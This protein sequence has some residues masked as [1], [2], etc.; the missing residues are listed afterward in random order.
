[1][2]AEARPQ[3]HWSAH[4]C[5]QAARLGMASSQSWAEPAPAA[6]GG[7]SLSWVV[8]TSPPEDSEI[9]LMC[10]THLDDRSTAVTCRE[11]R[12]AEDRPRQHMEV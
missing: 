7:R 8:R 6:R 12:P 1:M 9:D 5:V 2:H 10:E 3:H 4:P 11:V